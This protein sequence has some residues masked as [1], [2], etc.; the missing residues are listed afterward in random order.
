MKVILDTNV[1]VSVLI[2]P[3][4]GTEGIYRA[5]RAGR[6]QLLTCSEQFTEFRRVTRYPRVRSYIRPS[7]AGTLLNELR[8][9]ASVIEKLPTVEILAD[10]SDAFL[11]GLA[12][13]GHADYLV[14]GDQSHLLEMR[15]YHRTEIVSVRHMIRILRR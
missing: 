15:R 12:L 9:L 5:W 4:G 14:T 11:L 6:F 8:R 7:E 1:L 10:P 3:K 2:T 13:A